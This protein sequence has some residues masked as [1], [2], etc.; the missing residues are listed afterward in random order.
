MRFICKR[1]LVFKVAKIDI[2]QLSLTVMAELRA[3]GQAT[4]E[5]VEKAVEETA[6][7]TVN[8]LRITSPVGPTGDY[9]KSWRKKRDNTAKGRRKFNMIVYAKKPDYRIAHLLE[10]GHAKKNGGRT[11]AFPHI[12]AAEETAIKRLENKIRKGIEEVRK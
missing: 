9:A 4:Y 3:Y 6:Q 2:D 8:E 7:E 5:Q 11:R 12:K 1:K 10:F